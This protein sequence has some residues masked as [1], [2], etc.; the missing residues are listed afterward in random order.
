[1]IFDKEFAEYGYTDLVAYSGKD[2]TDDMLNAC[3]IIEKKFFEAEYTESTDNLIE[4]VK[5]YNQMCFVFVDKVKNA[6]VGYSFWFPIK[7][8]VFNA[9]IE[10]DFTLLELR[11]NFFSS[12]KEPT[13]NL[14]L[15]SEAYVLG[16]DI[17]RLHEAVEDVF[18]RRI[19]DL[20]YK[21]TKVKYIA[22]EAVCDYDE[23]FLVKLLGLTNKVKK[24]KSTFYYGEYTP[25]TVYKSSKYS[26]GIKQYYAKLKASAESK[27]NTDKK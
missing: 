7:T 10:N 24:S 8:K 12:Y 22:I 2:I 6:V 20:A 9:Y 25:E 11:D 3:K 27:K 26:S 18:S 19:L 5:K 16:Y 4:C 1:M 13:I 23:K 21:G 14:F 17:K 15:A